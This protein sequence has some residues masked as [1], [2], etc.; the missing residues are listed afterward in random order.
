VTVD[1]NG[2]VVITGKSTVGDIIDG[3]S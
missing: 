3:G 1:E 2:S